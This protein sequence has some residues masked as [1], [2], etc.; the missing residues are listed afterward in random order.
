MGR[1]PFFEGS[2]RISWSCFN[3]WK[4]KKGH[5]GQYRIEGSFLAVTGFWWEKI[6]K[7]D[8]YSN[9]AFKFKFQPTPYIERDASNTLCLL[10]QQP[11]GALRLL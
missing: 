1:V 11:N 5:Q 4:K 2:I 9:A 3:P 6:R 7:Q 8:S 10:V